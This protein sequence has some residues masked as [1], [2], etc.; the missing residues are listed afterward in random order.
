[1]LLNGLQYRNS[2]IS[3]ENGKMLG[4]VAVS[5]NLGLHKK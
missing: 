1:M 3:Y 5:T 2:T 4:M